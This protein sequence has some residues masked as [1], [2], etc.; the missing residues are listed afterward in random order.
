MGRF[1]DKE[2]VHFVEIA[3][4]SLYESMCQMELALDLNYIN[5]E[6]FTEVEGMMVEIAKMLSGL[7]NAI[8]NKINK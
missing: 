6:E 8:Q 2:K 7:R 4:G 1:S 3:Y 5:N